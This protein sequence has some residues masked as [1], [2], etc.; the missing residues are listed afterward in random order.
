[1]ALIFLLF[2]FLPFQVSIFLQIKLPW[3]YRR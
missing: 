3:L 2:S 1:M